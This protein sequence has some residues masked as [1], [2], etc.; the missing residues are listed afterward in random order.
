MKLKYL[1]EERKLKRI[2]ISLK[3]DNQLWLIFELDVVVFFYIKPLLF[4]VSHYRGVPSKRFTGSQDVT[5]LLLQKW[6][7]QWG[8]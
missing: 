1:F 8:E 7:V 3:S 6:D 2:K 5:E 4:Q